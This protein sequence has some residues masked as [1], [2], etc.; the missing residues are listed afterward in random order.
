M[1]K[2][3]GVYICNYN[4]QDYVIKCVESVRKQ[5]CINMI[6]IYVVDNHSTDDSVKLLRDTLGDAITILENAENLGGSGGF[7]RGI[8]DGLSK[9]YKYIMLVDNDVV[10]AED[11]VEQLFDYLEQNP[12]VGIAGS[13]I[14]QMGKPDVIQDLGG[15]I[16]LNRYNMQG[17]YY[18]HLDKG[19]PDV[20]EC[21]YVSTCTAM[22]RVE[23]VRQFGLMPEDN[24]I[25][26]DD[27]QWS[28]ECQ[29]TGYKT[30]VVSASKVWHNHSVMTG[31]SPFVKYYHTRNRLYYFSKYLEESQLEM[32]QNKIMDEI[33]A[34][35]YGCIHKGKGHVA[36]TLVYALEDFLT[37]KMGKADAGRIVESHNDSDYHPLQEEL[38]SKRHILVDF[39]NKLVT[40]DMKYK[41]IASFL[42]KV[43]EWNPE[44]VVDIFAE[45]RESFEEEFAQAIGDSELPID[46]GY[47]IIEKEQQQK[48][49]DIEIR[50]CNHVKEVTKNILPK[51]YVDYY[52]NCIAT[53]EQYHFFRDYKKEQKLFHEKYN[54]RLRERIK[55]IRRYCI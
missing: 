42:F 2:N 41:M 3:I 43:Q 11:A 48:N 16:D 6:D 28:K 32:F 23:A 53:M 7:N 18:G 22:A 20:I 35:G 40:A 4:K 17:N 54:S 24:F 21:D 46:I 52:L 37:G 39:D 10:M 1:D 14:L 55:E 45:N 5:T 51:V 13:K 19:L 38:Q 27:T 15:S 26:W 34:T 31:I 36:E 44:A 12:D 50:F 49:Y 30:I 25:Y 9:D 29:Q 47:R 8:R 33:F